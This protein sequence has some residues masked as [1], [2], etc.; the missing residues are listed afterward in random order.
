[1]TAAI[2]SGNDEIARLLIADWPTWTLD[3][4]EK[5]DKTVEYETRTTGTHSANVNVKDGEGITPLWAAVA[6]N[7]YGIIGE[8][9]DKNADINEKVL[10]GRTVLHLAAEQCPEYTVKLLLDRN[11]SPVARDE[12]N[13]TPYAVAQRRAD[14]AIMRLIWDKGG[15]P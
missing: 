15:R 3:R 5:D 1:M 14:E 7:N 8:L 10:E 11:A 4:I 13:E 12:K 9:L 2:K 6:A